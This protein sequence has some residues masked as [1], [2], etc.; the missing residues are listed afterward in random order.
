MSEN[1]YLIGFMGSGK[2]TLGKEIATT[3]DYNWVD[4]DHYIEAHQ[5]TTIKELFD[6]FGESTFRKL[7]TSSLKDLIP[8]RQLVVSTGGGIIVTPE[9]ISLLKSQTT[10][11]L[12]W[13]FDTLY[14]R[15]CDD[16]NRPLVKSYE[17][18]LALYNK[19]EQLY[20]EACTKVIACE[21]K[22]IE[23]ITQEIIR[24]MEVEDENSSY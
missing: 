22:S 3:L 24:L 13:H 17:Q 4:L 23:V 14:N 19:R 21:G 5:K 15:V 1:I 9:N 18:L 20:K 7:E 8:K 12:K 6:R 11:Y 2:S 10:F 16:K